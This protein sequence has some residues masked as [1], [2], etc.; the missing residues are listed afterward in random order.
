M[1]K[2]REVVGLLLHAAGPAGA[3]GAQLVD[4]VDEVDHLDHH[5]P[6]RGNMV[7]QTDLALA[8]RPQDD[9]RDLELIGE[10][11]DRY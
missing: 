3:L 8:A 4:D 9:V 1:V 11:L 10:L 2:L 6:A 5:L 7:S